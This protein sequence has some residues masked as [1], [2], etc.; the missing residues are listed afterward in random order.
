MKRHRFRRVLASGLLRPT[1][2]LVYAV[3]LGR[4]GQIYHRLHNGQLTLGRAEEV[5]RVLGCN[6]YGK[7]PRIGQPDVFRRHPYHTSREEQRIF[8]A[9]DH[10]RQPIQRSLHV[11]ASHRLVQRRNDVVVLFTTLVVAGHAALQHRLHDIG[12]DDLGGWCR[13][14]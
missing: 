10:S 6:S 2:R 4:G 12:R 9:V 7:R 14:Q 11:A 13:L 5:I 3:R 8:A 1:P